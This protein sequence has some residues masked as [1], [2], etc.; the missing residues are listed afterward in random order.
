MYRKSVVIII[1]IVLLFSISFSIPGL[2]GGKKATVEEDLKI[3]GDLKDKSVETLLV[4]N[5]EDNEYVTVGQV[6]T[7]FNRVNNKN[8]SSYDSIKEYAYNNNVY[9]PSDLVYDTVA[10][11]NMWR[12]MML[13]TVVFEKTNESTYA[14][15]L[16]QGYLTIYLNQQGYDLMKQGLIPPQL[17]FY[18]PFSG[19]RDLESINLNKKASLG[20]VLD[21]LMSC[22]VQEG[23]NR[24]IGELIE[25]RVVS[26]T[27]KETDVWTTSEI[28]LYNYYALSYY[29]E[30]AYFKSKGYIDNIEFQQIMNNVSVGE[31]LIIY[32]KMTDKK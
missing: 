3:L 25:D 19:V 31:L 17:Y 8:E 11:E 20:F 22:E 2:F 15:N 9:L 26:L 12:D 10:W 7:F 27:G 1:C 6:L 13:G 32:N 23:K 24:I 28:S 5:Y 30:Y 21:V 29:G 4:T 14:I 16:V 18:S